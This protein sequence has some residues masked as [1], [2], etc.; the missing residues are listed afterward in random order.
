MH[1]PIDYVIVGFNGNK[2]DGSILREIGTAVESGVIELV[3]LSVVAKDTDGVVTS[4]NIADL[5]DEYLLH[6]VEEHPLHNELVDTSDIAEVADLLEP[7]TA[8][9]LLVIEHLWAKPLKKAIADA[10]GYLIAD[11][12]IHPDAAEELNEGGE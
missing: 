4:L 5:G 11:G 8:A 6:F 3:A 12:R 10:G 1:G 7:N 2:F 9:G